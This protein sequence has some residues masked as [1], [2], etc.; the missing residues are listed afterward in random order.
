[1]YAQLAAADD[2]DDEHAPIGG[3]YG[4]MRDRPGSNA[5]STNKVVFDFGGA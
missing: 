5:S 3:A 4:A 2:D 1:M